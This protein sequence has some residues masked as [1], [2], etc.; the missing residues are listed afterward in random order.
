MLWNQ[1]KGVAGPLPGD[2][3]KESTGPV[4]AQLGD[5]AEGLGAGSKTH[6]PELC[7]TKGETESV[8]EQQTLLDT[9]LWSAVC[10]ST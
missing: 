9:R 5:G 8:W 2:S 6:S 7:L 3:L 4:W 10:L 1:R